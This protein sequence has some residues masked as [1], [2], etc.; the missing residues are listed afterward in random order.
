M[1]TTSWVSRYQ[2]GKPFWTS[3]ARVDEGGDGDSWRAET[4]A[5]HLYLVP[6][7]S[8][9]PV[10]QYSNS[11][12]HSLSASQPTVSVSIVKTVVD[13]ATVEDN[14]NLTMQFVCLKLS[15]IS[16]LACV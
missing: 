4:C 13:K 8:P 7:R 6:V 1:A 2:N 11:H 12:C 5:S 14:E 15:D 3:A 10:R 16:C 9:P